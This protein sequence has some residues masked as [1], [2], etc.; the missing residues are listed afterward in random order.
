MGNVVKVEKVAIYHFHAK[1]IGRSES[2]RS[3]TGA[4]A[5]RAATV[6]KD[7][8]TGLIHDYT[9][10]RGVDYTTILAP[11]H[12]PNW[13]FDRATLWNAVE[14][15]EK[16]K[17]SQLC[18]EIEVA[19][20][21]EFSFAQM[22]QLVVSFAES[23]FVSKGMIADIA[24]HNVHGDNPHAHILLTMRD[25]TQ[26]G[27]GLKNRD[28]NDKKLLEI[29][30]REWADAVNYYLDMYDIEARVDHRTLEAQGIERVP[31][32][33]LGPNVVQLEKRGIRTDRGDQ[34]RAIEK[35]NAKIIDLVKYRE[36]IHQEIERETLAAT[37]RQAAMGAARAVD[38]GDRGQDA[39]AANLRLILS[40]SGAVVDRTVQ[41]IERQLKG[42]G[43]TAYELHIQDREGQVLMRTWS[44]E[45]ILQ[46]IAWL[47]RQNAKGADIYI[48]PVG[49]ENRGLILLESLNATQLEHMKKQGIAPAV[50][51]EANPEKYQAW[52][53][54]TDLPLSPAVAVLAG[55]TLA[56]HFDT[57]YSSSAFGQLA[58]LTN[59]NPNY[60]TDEGR[61]PFILCREFSGQQAKRGE[62]MVERAEAVVLKRKAQVELEKQSSP[63]PSPNLFF[64]WYDYLAERNA[65]HAEKE[66]ALSELEARQEAE[67]ER[68]NAEQKA[69]RKLLL[70]QDWQWRGY[71]FKALRSTLAAE[72]AAEKA[73]LRERRLLER[74]A[75]RERYRDFAD[76]NEWL[77]TKG[78][79][80]GGHWWQDEN[81]IPRIQG[82][83]SVR[84]VPRD[85]RAYQPAVHNGYVY[86]SHPL[87]MASV[88]FVDKGREIDVFDWRNRDGVLAALQ[89]AAQKFG[90]FEVTGNNEF[91]LLCVQLAAEH[92]FKIANPELQDQ[93]KQIRE[94]WSKLKPSRDAAPMP[95]EPTRPKPKGPSM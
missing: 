70:D 18:R 88:S 85:I 7:E 64:S 28:W 72:Q 50:V 74:A 31:Q 19:L 81:E 61:H 43:C 5:Y 80:T 94:S 77:R 52:I 67:K 13:V 25:I 32:I 40:G 56:R 58:G 45:N 23:Q 24:F 86:Y 22:G 53:R 90:E 46:S 92:G 71:E 95:Q 54:L 55:K 1:Q 73:A 68:I 33:H 44:S 16:R 3:A 69:R 83:L 79:Q 59:Q 34:A 11:T 4:S 17:D 9:R 15:A 65:L 39:P 8:R 42:M 35:T 75:L 36:A 6:I 21:R 60:T 26:D 49:D 78:H 30:R 29:W 63:A 84:P 76:F 2:G 38:S 93:V 48:R 41:A 20:P 47:K 62:E 87:N 66:K 10:K 12:A 57:T 37:K 27:F 14:K 91:K 89:L 82:G 51:V